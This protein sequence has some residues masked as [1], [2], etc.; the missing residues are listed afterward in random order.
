MPWGALFGADGLESKISVKNALILAFVAVEIYAIVTRFETDE[1]ALT[2]FK[3]EV[4]KEFALI[5][6]LHEQDI[7]HLKEQL[8]Y[9]RERN[10]RKFKRLEK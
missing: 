3:K 5:K 10:E 2:D 1:K 4:G 9:E 6:E 7:A 8:I